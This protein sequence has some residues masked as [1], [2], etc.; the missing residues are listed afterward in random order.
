MEEDSATQVSREGANFIWDANMI[1]FGIY[2]DYFSK[3]LNGRRLNDIGSG[4]GHSSRLPD[5]FDIGE[6]VMVDPFN[7]PERNRSCYVD[8][9]GEDYLQGQ[10]EGS[11]NVL[12]CNLD[13]VI[14][15]PE[16]GKIMAEQ[17][18]RVVPK[19]G[20][21]VCISSGPIYNHANTLFDKKN[22]I[23]ESFVAF[24]K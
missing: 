14:L 13:E 8:A 6:L 24:E 19:G 2:R 15:G 4:R 9:Y 5:F 22:V 18:H 7:E 11:G 23:N 12:T 3:A 16:E 21:Y 20:A 1:L 10:E 17:I